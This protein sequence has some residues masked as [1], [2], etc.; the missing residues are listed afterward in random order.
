[1][2]MT[3]THQCSKR[4]INGAFNGLLLAHNLENGIIP[5][6]PISCTTVGQV[7]AGFEE[8]TDVMFLRLP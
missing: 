3:D 8:G 1:M 6:R 4:P 2:M 5:S 7:S